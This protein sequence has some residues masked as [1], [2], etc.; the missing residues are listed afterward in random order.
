MLPFSYAFRNLLRE[1]AHVIQ[2]V[3]GS[4]LVLFLILAAGAFNQGMNRLL[5]TSGSSHN[6]ILMGAGSEESV[7]RSQIP[8]RTESMAIAGIRGIDQRAGFPAVS[9]EV[10]YMGVL[11]FPGGHTSQGLMR[12]V[13][14]AAFEV[15][16]D[17][18]IIEGHWPR[19]GEVMVG[20][21]A[22]FVLG[23]GS[24]EM[25]VGATILL[26]GQPFRISGRFDAVGTVMESEIWFNRTDLMTLIQRE[27]LSCVV[28]RLANP[29]DFSR[30]DLFAKQ[31]LDLELTA[32]PESAYYANLARFYGPIRGMIW[33]TAALVAVGAVMGGLNILYASFSARVQ[34][35]A[36][37]Q[38]LGYR[39]RVVLVSLIQESL[40]IQLIGL[41]VG[42][43]LA[44]LLLEGVV[45]QFSMG[46]FQMELSPSVLGVAALTAI[47]LAT[48]GTLPPALRC[49]RL[50]VPIALHAGA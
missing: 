28:V 19:S 31:R 41:I 39:R 9:G 50:P 2:K 48:L 25:A 34:E 33:L 47:A 3:G 13:T 24:P 11:A 44:L 35:L 23:V 46:T 32:V 5:L 38:I 42:T 30:V 16:R 1:P 14:P 21:L 29:D 10:H 15:H 18:R 8:L 26:E 20:T 22:Q 12:G 40:F 7:E 27:S 37:L 45:V 49:L 6:V 17:V 36:T 4:A 43:I